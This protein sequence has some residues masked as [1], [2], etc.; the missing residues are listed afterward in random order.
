MREYVVWRV[1]D[2]EIDWFV[3]REGQYERFQPN[4]E[5]HL[6]SEVFPGLRLDPAALVRSDMATVLAT[7]QQGLE[8]PKHTAFVTRLHPPRAPSEQAGAE[9]D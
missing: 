1:L 4:L 7:G 5:G 3:L 9:T 6:R 8:S 2:Q